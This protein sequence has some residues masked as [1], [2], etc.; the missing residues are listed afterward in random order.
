MKNIPYSFKA[1]FDILPGRMPGK[2][3]KIREDM[4]MLEVQHRKG[5]KINRVYQEGKALYLEQ[6]SGF[7]RIL[8]QTDRI[9]RVS[10]TENGGFA[11]EQGGAA[12]RFVPGRRQLLEL[13]GRRK[14]NPGGHRISADEDCPRHRVPFPMKG[15]TAACCF[16]ERDR[17]SKCVE[18]SDSYRMVVN[19]NTQ[20]EEIQTPDGIKRRIR[21]ADR[22]LIKEAL[23]HTRL[24]LDFAP[25]EHLY[26][27]G[28]A[29]EGVM[30]PAP[31]HPV[32]ALRPI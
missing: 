7:I 31:Y 11:S 3:K 16:A 9:I 23:Y 15:R 26:G 20:I 27:L 5:R 18:A 24:H 1:Y 30:E 4:H 13:E 32:S 17:E 28:Q 22:V 6:E 12:G 29:E 25:E 19:E 14:G 8:P 21:E 10:Y 2:A